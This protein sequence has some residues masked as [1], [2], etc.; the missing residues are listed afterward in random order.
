MFKRKGSPAAK[1]SAKESE[2]DSESNESLED[3]AVDMYHPAHIGEILDYKY[4]LLK[5]LGWGH[6][7]TVWL[8]LKLQD[9]NLYALK[10]QKSKEAYTESALDELGILEIVAE[11]FNSPEW[12]SSVRNYLHDP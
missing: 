1:D 8:A 9:R 7:S 12:I 3:Y 11:N 5:K 4:L 2:S 6:F 10:I